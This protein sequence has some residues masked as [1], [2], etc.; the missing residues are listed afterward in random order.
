MSWEQRY[1]DSI[2]GILHP[3]Y[4][5]ERLAFALFFLRL[6]CTFASTLFLVNA[7]RTRTKLAFYGRN[8]KI[9]VLRIR[10]VRYTYVYVGIRTNG[11]FL[12]WNLERIVAQEAT[13]AK[14]KRGSQKWS[15]V[16]CG[17]NFA[18][19][20]YSYSADRVQTHNKAHM[21]ECAHASW[22]AIK[23]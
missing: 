13:N 16:R 2:S 22:H 19:F 20:N 12:L 23:V 15:R 21:H 14:T 6:P 10:S 5:D 8:L 11:H 17:R 4:T 18:R 3:W 9:S 7:R 1:R